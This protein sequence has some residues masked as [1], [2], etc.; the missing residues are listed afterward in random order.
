M[1]AAIAGGFGEEKWTPVAEAAYTP[2]RYGWTTLSFSVPEEGTYRV[3]CVHS[4]FMVNMDDRTFTDPLPCQGGTRRF[5][6][7]VEDSRYPL[8]AQ[9]IKI[10]GLTS[11]VATQPAA[12]SEGRL[13]VEALPNLSLT[14][15]WSGSVEGNFVRNVGEVR[16]VL[17]KMEL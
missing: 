4:A 5:A 15:T 3:R 7:P 6:T 12:M 10:N 9:L 16:F 14:R 2:N 17:E 8:A 11:A 1:G 13:Q